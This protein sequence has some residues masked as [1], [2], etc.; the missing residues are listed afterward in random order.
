MASLPSIGGYRGVKRASRACQRCHARKVRCDATVTGFPCTNCQLDNY[1]CQA[2]TGG[3]ERRKQLSLAEIDV[4]LRN[5]FLYVHPFLPL[6]NEAVVWRVY[7]NP[8]AGDKLIPLLLFRAMIFAATCFVP[9]EIANRCGYD[10]LLDAREDLYHKAKLLYDSGLEKDRLMISRATLLLSYYGSDFDVYANSRWLRIAITE[11]RVIPA[12]HRECECPVDEAER[13]EFRRIWWCCLIRDRTISLGMRRPLQITAAECNPYPQM[14]T[15]EDMNDEMFGSLVYS[16]EIK[17]VL[18]VLLNSL[19]HLVTAVAELVTIAFSQAQHADSG[20]E[21]LCTDLEKLELAKSAL[22]LWELD[23]MAYIEEKN[24]S[25]HPS[26]PL[27]SS[28]ISIYYH[29]ARVA[30]CNR[31]CLVLGKV[32]YHKPNYLQQL[33]LCESELVAAIACI[34][35]KVRRLNIIEAVDKLPISVTAYIT[36]PYILLTINSQSDSQKSR[37]LR[38]LFAAVNRTLSLRYRLTRVLN[39]TSRALWL[40]RMFKDA[41]G[42]CQG[43][44]EHWP[45]S[46]RRSVFTLP[47]QQYTR[48]LQY[49]DESMSIPRDSVQETELLYAVA[50]P[51]QELSSHSPSSPDSSCVGEEFMPVWI[52]AMANFFFGPGNALTLPSCPSGEKPDEVA[53]P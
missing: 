20:R 26:I 25:L 50:S 1:P 3:R 53:G 43:T 34:A 10:S 5:Y 12:R 40:S 36:T 16:Y 38:V 23:W 18:F 42:E 47:L 17:A 41:L 8:R 31:I 44:L 52:E 24:S 51:P 39:L 13:S 14:L 29:S 35:D 22:L 48:L 15:T 28:L 30:L 4:F 6:I 46:A 7:E 37:E 21:D 49:I 9:T 27:F 45:E 19:C 33:N 32:E 11:A 2:F